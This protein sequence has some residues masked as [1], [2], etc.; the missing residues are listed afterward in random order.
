[1]VSGEADAVSGLLTLNAF[2]SAIL[3]CCSTKT[4]R[5]R[6]FRA[7][8]GEGAWRRWGGD[9]SRGASIRLKLCGSVPNGSEP[10]PPATAV[11]EIAPGA[12]P[13]FL[14]QLSAY[15][16]KILMATVADKY[17]TSCMADSWTPEKH[18]QSLRDSRDTT[19][20]TCCLPG[21]VYS[22]DQQNMA[23]FSARAA[24][25][26]GLADAVPVGDIAKTK[27][28]FSA[29]S[30]EASSDLG[31]EECSARPAPASAATQKHYLA[32]TKGII[33]AREPDGHFSAQ[34]TPSTSLLQ[35]EQYVCKKRDTVVPSAQSQSS[36]PVDPGATGMA[37]HASLEAVTESEA[38]SA[39]QESE[40]FDNTLGDGENG[41]DGLD[42]G[43]TRQ[44]VAGVSAPTPRACEAASNEKYERQRERAKVG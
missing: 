39:K 35:Q 6:L 2:T 31:A 33:L 3:A 13:H 11:D 20:S 9:E 15:R 5:E 23:S 37:G 30:E 44:E 18:E 16:R 38:V 14:T 34:R 12:V 4:Q 32:V 43:E 19:I 21:N 40:R 8:R 1:M 24:S 42:A 29:P 28:S 36:A 41:A 27:I 10:N 17:P 22:Y 26:G 7:L 25:D